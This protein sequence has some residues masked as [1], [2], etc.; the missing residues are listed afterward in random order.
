MLTD[1]SK[2]LTIGEPGWSSAGWQDWMC[3]KYI[4]A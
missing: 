1:V 3:I 2:N 4:L